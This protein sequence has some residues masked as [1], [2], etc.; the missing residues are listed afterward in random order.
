MGMA[1]PTAFPVSTGAASTLEPS[2]KHQPIM[3]TKFKQHVYRNPQQKKKKKKKRRK[4]RKR[5]GGNDDKRSQSKDKQ[6]LTSSPSPSHNSHKIGTRANIQWPYQP[7]R[8]SRWWDLRLCSGRGFDPWEQV[9]VV[10][11]VEHRL[12][13]IHIKINKYKTGDF[14]SFPN[15]AVWP[16]HM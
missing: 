16:S 10:S 15:D 7:S 2:L 14:C 1:F 4:R 6:E 12:I 9:D 13:E 11:N 5:E 8:R 3:M